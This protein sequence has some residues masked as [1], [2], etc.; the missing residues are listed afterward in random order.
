MYFYLG[1]SWEGYDLIS[2]WLTVHVQDSQTNKHPFGVLFFFLTMVSAVNKLLV[3]PTAIL[4][5]R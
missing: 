3:L 1:I 4:I 5:V 2:I